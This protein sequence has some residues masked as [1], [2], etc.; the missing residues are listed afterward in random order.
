V[1][2]R[3]GDVYC[4]TFSGMAI[5]RNNPYTTPLTELDQ[6]KVGPSPLVIEEGRQNFVYFRNLTGNS[7]IK[8][9]TAN[10]QLV[11]I[12]DQSNSDDFLGSFA[13][14][15]CRNQDG[16]LV[17]SGIYLYLI[18]DE[19]GNATSGKFLIIRE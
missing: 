10:G 9:L 14:W 2:D 3:T 7:E 17:S 11:R 8:I 5:L 18:T 1:D 16:R 19:I 6:V 13:Q 4:G 12:L 15:N